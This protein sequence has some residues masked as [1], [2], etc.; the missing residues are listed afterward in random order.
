MDSNNGLPAWSSRNGGR[1]QRWAPPRRP[2][3]LGEDDVDEP[4][5]I[6]QE[7]LFLARVGYGEPRLRCRR[8]RGRS[9]A[10]AA[11]AARCRRGSRCGRS[12][13]GCSACG[14]SGSR[15]GR[16]KELLEIGRAQDVLGRGEEC[17]VGE[18][19]I[20]KLVK[21]TTPCWSRRLGETDPV[22]VIDSFFP[23]MATVREPCTWAVPSGLM[24]VTNTGT[25]VFRLRESLPVVLKLPPVRTCGRKENKLPESPPVNSRVR[26][27]ES[28]LEDEKESEEEASIW[29]TRASPT[30][31]ALLPDRYPLKSGDHRLSPLPA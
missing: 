24:A 6:E 12:R 26:F 20:G 7:Q 19:R 27:L 16:R 11:A 13:R 30:A 25:W 9:T 5:E 18:T 29:T 15:R 1:L 3:L 22:T 17:R 31:S 10:A 23:W 2:C 4:V 14:R 8:C 28:L 21:F